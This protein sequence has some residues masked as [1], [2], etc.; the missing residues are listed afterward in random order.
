MH[1]CS[2]YQEIT[3]QPASRSYILRNYVPKQENKANRGIQVSPVRSYEDM[4]RNVNFGLGD[5]ISHSLCNLE[6]I[7]TRIP[8]KANWLQHPQ[9]ISLKI[10]T[11]MRSPHSNITEGSFFPLYM[12]IH[13]PQTGHV[14]NLS[15]VARANDLYALI[16]LYSFPRTHFLIELQG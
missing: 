12:F 7:W 14:I 6:W 9:S 5:L 15:C 2:C 4:L 10:F 11:L 8:Y 16:W 13:C 1:K 3:S